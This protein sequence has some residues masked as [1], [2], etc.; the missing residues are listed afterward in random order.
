MIL[1]LS[2]ADLTSQ[3]TYLLA[4]ST[5]TLSI[6][7]TI[8]P[9]EKAAL[10]EYVTGLG[11]LYQKVGAKSVGKY[12]ISKTIFGEGSPSLVSIMQFPNE[13]AVDAVFNSPEYA[14]LMPL[15]DRAFL[16]VDGH[17]SVG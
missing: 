10:T 11:P 16:S 14:L 4:M 8:N 3:S 7:A 17:L 2:E 15:R 9:A 5:V 1:S 13:A 12:K 6:V